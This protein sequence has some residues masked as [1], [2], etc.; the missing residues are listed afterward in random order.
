[1]Y[2]KAIGTAY[3][4]DKNKNKFINQDNT[5]KLYE[6]VGCSLDSY[7]Y[8]R[9]QGCTPQSKRREFGKDKFPIYNFNTNK[10]LVKDDIIKAKNSTLLNPLLSEVY[11]HY[12]YIHLDD[13]QKVNDNNNWKQVGY[14]KNKQ[15]VVN[16]IL[17]EKSQQMLTSNKYSYKIKPFDSKDY[18]LLEGNCNIF[19]CGSKAINGSWMSTV[20]TKTGEKKKSVQIFMQEGINLWKNVGYAGIANATG[21][22][23]KF[24]YI[25][26]E[27]ILA[28]DLYDYRMVKN[29]YIL[30]L[31]PGNKAVNWEARYSRVNPALGDIPGYYILKIQ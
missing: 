14:A 29:N 19:N 21:R 20:A 28:N 6:Y 4:I 22:P 7:F 1:M 30:G 17:Y 23:T 31:Q 10:K 9:I 11:T 18:M 3:E 27:R 15:G 26:Q 5:Y 24:D 16:F 25:L 12:F 8:Y 2:W 13:T